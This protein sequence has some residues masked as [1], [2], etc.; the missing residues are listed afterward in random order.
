ML[1]ASGD[2]APLEYSLASEFK[3]TVAL[4]VQ[5]RCR[6]VHARGFTAGQNTWKSGLGHRAYG[7]PGRR[8]PRAAGRGP[9]GPWAARPRARF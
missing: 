7:P 2:R 3:L 9:L 8:G 1:V 4:H 5:T 6:S